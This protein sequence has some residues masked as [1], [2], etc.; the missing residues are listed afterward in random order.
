MDQRSYS[1]RYFRTSWN[2]IKGSKGW[3]GKICLLG[4]ISFIPIFGQMT[5]YGY[6]YEWAHK[7]AWGV[8]G[9]MPRKIYGRSG[10]KMLR[11][12]WFALVI[13]FV[14]SLVPGIISSI[15]SWLTGMGSETGIYTSMGRYM[16]VDGGNPLLLILGWLVNVAGIV[17]FVFAILFVMA[18]TM[19]MTMYDRL[20][21]GFSFGKIWTM[22]KH[23][24]GGIMRIFGMNLLFGFVGG[25]VIAGVTILLMVIVLGAT[26]APLF[27][28]AGSGAYYSDSAIVGYIIAMVMAMLPLL[29][30]MGYITFVYSAFVEILVARA[31]GY[32]MRQ[33]DVARWG[34]QD[35]P[36][37]FELE[38]A[39]YAAPTEPVPPHDAAQPPAPSCAVQQDA[40]PAPPAGEPVVEASSVTPPADETPG[41]PKA[42]QEPN[43][44]L[45]EAQALDAEPELPAG[46]DES[47]DK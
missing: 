6:A 13:A 17:A 45:L 2:D 20:G 7:A 10:S 31:L 5:V 30:V 8:E 9:P 42:D 36:L 22:I 27:I 40:T 39:Q 47:K 43:R 15:G 21:A 18:G 16:V 12:G 3:F 35:D 25:F 4:L 24:F 46:E 38:G 41:A 29:L 26:A 1:G 19:R 44:I 37:P 23:D 11:W 14:F 33:F 32:W 28:M 34:K